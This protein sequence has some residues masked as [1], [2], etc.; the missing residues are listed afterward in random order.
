MT[1]TKNRLPLVIASACVALLCAG[2]IGTWAWLTDTTDSLK[3]TFTVGD[4][5]IDLTETTGE[6]YAIVPGVDVDKDPFVT[7][8]SGSEAMWVFVTLEESDDFST[9]LTYTVDSSWIALD[10]QSGVYYQMVDADENNDQ[11]LSVLADDKVEVPSTL[12]AS[13]L[14]NI[15]SDDIYLT[16]S[17]A[18][19][20]QNTEFEDAADA[21]AALSAEMNA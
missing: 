1:E 12:T 13:D 17:A 15:S 6:D 7:V 2:A 19:I 10:G 21:W 5:D 8:E 14:A 4:V 9:Y 16:V 3:N 20:Q 11:I 18:A